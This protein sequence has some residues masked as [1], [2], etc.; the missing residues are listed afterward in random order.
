MRDA[1]SLFP[2]TKN[3]FVLN[4][5]FRFVRGNLLSSAKSGYVRILLIHTHSDE[6]FIG[7]TQLIMSIIDEAVKRITSHNDRKT[8]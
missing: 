2:D 6:Y 1:N 5:W 7:F 8:K 4:H 3:N